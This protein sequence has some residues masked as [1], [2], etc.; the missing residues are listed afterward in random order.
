MRAER[1]EANQGEQ[2]RPQWQLADA[3]KRRRQGGRSPDSS[4]A[5]Q[6]GLER[7]RTLELV[8][9]NRKKRKVSS[10][11]PSTAGPTAADSGEEDWCTQ[12][13]K[14]SFLFPGKRPS[15]VEED[16][17]AERDERGHERRKVCLFSHQSASV[18]QQ[19]NFH[20]SLRHMIFTLAKRLL[21]QPNLKHFVLHCSPLFSASGV[22]ELGSGRSASQKVS[23]WIK[24]RRSLGTPACTYTEAVRLIALLLRDVGPGACVSAEL[25]DLVDEC[26][27][28]GGRSF[29]DAYSGHRKT[30]PTEP[31]GF[32]VTEA[33]Q[34]TFEQCLQ[35][36]ILAAI[37]RV[38]QVQWKL[39]GQAAEC[40]S[41]MRGQICCQ[42][43]DRLLSS[44]QM[45]A[46]VWEGSRYGTFRVRP[47]CAVC[48]RMHQRKTAWSLEHVTRS[49]AQ[50]RVGTLPRHA[51]YSSCSTM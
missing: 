50:V 29:F 6:A 31:H 15:D 10:R 51:Y 5:G 42:I 17:E 41:S 39:W 25:L 40:T 35:E 33:S 37:R 9:P 46:A 13:E 47:I 43:I 23:K 14:D 12:L 28:R 4:C 26:V 3:G 19:P 1:A 16:G 30:L 27:A 7:S 49:K 34:R 20:T 21:Q 8:C 36:K 18:Q 44:Q 48:R 24:L 2:G 45:Q 11:P 22:S 38:E 32:L